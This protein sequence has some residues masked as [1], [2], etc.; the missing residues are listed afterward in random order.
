MFFIGNDK[1]LCTDMKPN[2]IISDLFIFLS[3]TH[4]TMFVRFFFF[5]D[6]DLRENKAVRIHYNYV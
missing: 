1:S 2:Y 4:G 6:F 3:I 5:L